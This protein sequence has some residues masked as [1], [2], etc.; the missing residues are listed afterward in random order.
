MTNTSRVLSLKKATGYHS[1]Q[2]HSLILY[3]SI[4]RITKIS[5][6]LGELAMFQFPVV[7]KLQQVKNNIDH[8]AL[9]HSRVIA[10]DIQRNQYNGVQILGTQMSFVSVVV[11][12]VI[13]DYDSYV[14]SQRKRRK[15]GASAMTVDGPQSSNQIPGI[16]MSFIIVCSYRFLHVQYTSLL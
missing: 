2:P 7:E 8:M 10:C 11:I 12:E 4:Y 16:S 13:D 6:K 14:T 5:L 9:R 15:R 1:R 3:V